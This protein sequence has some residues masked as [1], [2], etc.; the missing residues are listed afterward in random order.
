M[1]LP[2]FCWIGLAVVVLPLVAAAAPP[3]EHPERPQV[4]V[5][6]PPQAWAVKQVLGDAVE[7]AVL[8]PP[9][10]DPETFSL[11]P[12]G[13]KAVA[14]AEVWFRI[15]L[16]F[17]AAVAP[18]LAEAGTTV[19]DATAG[20]RF[21]QF[22]EG[23]DH[24]HHDHGDRDHD[25]H[26]DHGDPDKGDHGKGDHD[27]GDPDHGDG[28]GGHGG[29]APDH[30]GGD[31]GKAE[32]PGDAA[33][34][35]PRASPA[36]MLDPHVWLSPVNM[37]RMLTNVAEVDWSAHGVAA[38]IE[39]NLRRAEAKIGF[40]EMAVRRVLKP[41]RNEKVFVFHPAFGYFCD[42]FDLRQVPLERLGK[43]PSPR[44]LRDVVA[45]VRAAGVRTI[46]VQPQ[47]ETS[48]A[49]AVAEAIGGETAVLDP[50]AEQ[51]E[52][53]LLDMAKAIAAS[54]AED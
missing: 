41:H 10:R 51:W 20:M 47:F 32:E 1:R 23:V 33:A 25:D 34:G 43:A 31:H 18:A 42:H 6:I 3:Q 16:P 53:N 22:R 37:R 50:L 28:H 54:F 7:V 26:E 17:E 30:G 11:S 14:D 46:F 49:Q 19:I 12:K 35:P 2:L 44:Q 45:E 15:G 4:L 40:I 13:L 24:H 9:N 39:G 21:R 29:D 27:K 52:R 36:Q 8:L 38:D 5:S 48:A